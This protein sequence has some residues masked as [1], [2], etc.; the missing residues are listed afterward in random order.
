MYG[1]GK[2]H[3]RAIKKSERSPGRAHT[4]V[5]SHGA[6]ETFTYHCSSEKGIRGFKRFI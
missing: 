5:V 3:R 6:S 4:T 2:V 1:D